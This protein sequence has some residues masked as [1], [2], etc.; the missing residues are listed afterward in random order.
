[1]NPSNTILVTGGTGFVG[2]EVVRQLHEAGY[3]VR[4]L[5]RNTSH[6]E[7]W[8]KYLGVQ[9]WRGDVTKRESLRGACEGVSAVVHLV[10]IIVGTWR[11]NFQQAHVLGTKNILEEAKSAGVKRFLHMSALGTRP[12]GA[13]RYHQTKWDAEEVVRGSD[14]AWTIFRPSLIYGPGGHFENILSM[15]LKT[16]VV[17]WI[18]PCIEG[19]KTIMQ[20]VAVDEVAQAFVHSIGLPSTIGKTIDLV[21]PKITL[22]KMIV[23]IATA[24]GFEPTIT[25]RPFDSAIFHLPW[26]IMTRP[27]PILF[28]FPK[29]ISYFCSTILEFIPGLNLINRDHVTMLLEDQFGDAS[30][31]EKILRIKPRPFS[32]G[33]RA[34]LSP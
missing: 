1:M 12:H 31:E 7:A 11:Q 21:G 15:L 17:G 14:L 30:V 10:G 25:E 26:W 18:F 22:R 27:K 34:Y 2:R 19:G 23:E 3:T 33:I 32:E 24:I 9:L 5:V 16:P 4:V 20:P 29:E 28:P 13:S 6:Y 8:A